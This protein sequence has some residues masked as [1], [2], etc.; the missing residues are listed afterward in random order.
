MYAVYILCAMIRTMRL[1]NRAVA[2]QYRVKGGRDKTKKKKKK[3]KLMVI[4]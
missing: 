4:W 2:A 3:I 1:V